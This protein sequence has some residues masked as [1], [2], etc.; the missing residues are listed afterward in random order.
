MLD[1]NGDYSE[2]AG[3]ASTTQ[4]S[5]T[6]SN[7]NLKIYLSKLTST[8]RNIQKFIRAAKQK[9]EKNNFM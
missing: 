5:Q 4:T 6:H 8:N 2:I 9:Y 3:T 7:E 1:E